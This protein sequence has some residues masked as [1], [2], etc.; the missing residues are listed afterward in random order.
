LASGATKKAVVYRFDREALSGFLDAATPIEGQVVSLLS[1]EGNLQ[2]LP[3]ETVKVIAFVRDWPEPKPWLRPNYTVRPRQ[4]GLWVRLRF[5]DGECVE[6][7]MQNNLAALDPAAI[8]VTPP[9]SSPGL[10]KVMVPKSALEGFEV[11]GVIG[12]PLKKGKKAAP[13]AQLRMFE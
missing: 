5:R 3:L 2:V 10:Q 6:A 13:A 12:S 8:V 1:P 9:E 4:Q 11:L 7:T